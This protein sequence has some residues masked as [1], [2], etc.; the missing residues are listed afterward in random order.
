VAEDTEDAYH[1][2]RCVGAA[3]GIAGKDGQLLSLRQ[4]ELPH[5]VEGISARLENDTLDLLLVTDADDPTIPAKLL[6][7][8]LVL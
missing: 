4:L 3:I 8:S 7:A 1:D 5:K 6:S 2:G